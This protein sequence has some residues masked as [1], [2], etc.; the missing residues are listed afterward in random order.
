MP[1][2]QFDDHFPDSE[3]ALLAGPEAC[4]LHLFA[5]TWCCAHLTDGLIPEIVARQFIDK[6]E[7]GT[8]LVARLID[9]GLWEKVDDDDGGWRLPYFLDDNRS[10]A[11]VENDRAKKR[12]NASKG[13]NAKALKDRQARST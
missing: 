1:W 3:A 4:G 6:C 2:A 8:G 10:K 9:A 12:K 13:G 5:T 7:D 11:T